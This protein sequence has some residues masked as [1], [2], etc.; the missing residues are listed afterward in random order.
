LQKAIFPQKKIRTAIIFINKLVKFA[1]PEKQPDLP[2]NG[3][4]KYFSLRVLFF[5][6]SFYIL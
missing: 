1:V 5:T 2:Q 3:R 6:D 4:Q